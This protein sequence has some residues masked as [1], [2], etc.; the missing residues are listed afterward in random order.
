MGEN[1]RFYTGAKTAGQGRDCGDAKTFTSFYRKYGD[2]GNLGRSKRMAKH[3]LC[4]L[5][6]S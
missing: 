4:S 6:W 2:W 3:N 1:A 5:L